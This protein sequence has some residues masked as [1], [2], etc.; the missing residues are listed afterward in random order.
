MIELDDLEQT[1]NQSR[2]A[3]REAVVFVILLVGLMSMQEALAATKKQFIKQDLSVL[4]HQIETYLMAQSAGYAG[5]TTVKAGAIDPNLKLGACLQPEVF[6]PP[7]SRAWGRTTVGV[8]CDSPVR[9]KIYV[10][11]TVRVK[12]Q[13]LVTAYPLP[14]GHTISKQDLAFAEGDLARMPAGVFTDASQIVGQVVRSPLM[15]GSVL[16]QNMLKQALAV[17]QGQTVML[18][19]A[20]L[21]FTINAEGKALRNASMGQVV[22]VKVPNGQ[23]VSGI[24]KPGGKVEVRF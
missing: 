11:A 8:Q 20:G 9:W 21:G 19:T 13:Y 7:G 4:K 6:L 24:A 5:T 12:G 10:Q 14:Q 17:Q 1:T 2:H 15:A 16:R 23:V 22:Q 18:T 3:W